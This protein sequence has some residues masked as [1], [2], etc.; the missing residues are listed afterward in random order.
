MLYV[1]QT[2]PGLAEMAWSEAETALT[3]GDRRPHMVGTKAVPGR[4]DLLLI[5]YDGSPRQL[6]NLRISEDAF[7]VAARGF[8]VASDE[9]GLRQI[10]AAVR[11]SELIAPA[12]GIWRQIVGRRSGVVPFRV[13]ARTVGQHRFMRRDVGRAV[14]D[15][16]RDSWPGQWRSVEEGDDVEIWATLI[17]DD[18]TVA[19]RLSDASMRQRGK[20]KHLPASLRPALAAAMV[21]LSVPEED[22][23]FLDPMA[24]AG[25]IL[26]ERAAAGPYGEIHGGDI[27][28]EAVAAMQANLRTIKGRFHTSRWDARRLPFEDGEV[29]KVVANLPFGKQISDE[30][31]IHDLY[32]AFLAEVARVMRPGGRLVLLAGSVNAVERARLAAARSLR[33][34]P[35]HRVIVLGHPATILE[36]T[37]QSGPVHPEPRSQRKAPA[38]V[39]SDSPSEAVDDGDY[40]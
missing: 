25:T 34:G 33:P 35:R 9:R 28:G 32:Q 5:D 2:I 26:A 29:D 17:E 21:H 11:G 16:I 13:I 1:L 18:L 38:P 39:P 10:H 24:G 8:R 36:Y 27:S 3:K 20:L 31:V 22:D 6:L 19:I 15:A 4:D 12:L 7:V 14:A 23:I 40:Y 30:V 37:R